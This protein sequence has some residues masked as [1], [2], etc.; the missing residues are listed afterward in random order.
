MNKSELIDAVADKA[1]LTKA[2]AARAVDAFIDTVTEALKKGDS[3]TLIGFGTF[4][5]KERAERQG[6]NPRT[7]EPMV[8][9]AA[10]IPAFK[11][12]KTL[13]DAVQ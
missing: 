13:K 6:R 10:K 1:N 8:I 5:I 2:D 12:G 4:T 7:G 3:V 9:K 11:P